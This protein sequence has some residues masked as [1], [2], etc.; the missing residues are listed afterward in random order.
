LDISGT[1]TTT[2]LIESALIEKQESIPGKPYSD[3]YRRVAD[4]SHP[5]LLNDLAVRP[6]NIVFAATD[7]AKIHEMVGKVRVWVRQDRIRV[8]ARCK[9]L[10]GCLSSGIW[11]NQRTEFERSKAYGHYDA[12]AALVYLV[13]NIDEYTNPIPDW[14]VNPDR[15]PG[16]KKAPVLSPLG[17]DMKH[18]FSRG[19]K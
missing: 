15:M 7:K 8:H 14:Y 5:L 13:R 18:L 11:N 17:Q 2:D 16:V 4:N 3:P 10:I 6:A 1:T 12:L 19:P 9:Q